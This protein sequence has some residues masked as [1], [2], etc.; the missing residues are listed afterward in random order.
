MIISG[1]PVPPTELPDYYEPL[2]RKLF[3]VME[4]IGASIEIRDVRKETSTLLEIILTLL[5][6]SQGNK[7]STYICGS[8][9]EGTTT[10]GMQ[11]DRDYL[12]VYDDYPVVADK[13]SAQQ[14][15]QCI[16][17]IQD[18]HT[19]AGYAKLQLMH[20]GIPLS[21]DPLR[22]SVR[23]P[24]SF[25]REGRVVLDISSEFE[26]MG[27]NTIRH[28][29]ALTFSIPGFGI[30]GDNVPAV[31]C[32]SWPGCATEW[33]TR[34]RPYNWPGPVLF[35]KCKSLG[36]FFVHV[37]HP[38]SYEKHLQW[39]VSFS[40]QE[41]L[42]VTN[43]NSTQLKCYI[44]MKFMKKE[45]LQPLLKE[46]TITSYHCKTC[47][48]YM[49]EN[50]PAAFWKPERLLPCL[51]SC[52]K[53]I[54]R[55]AE[56]GVCPNFF[57]PDENMFD[58]RITGQLRMRLCSAL[59][60][61][62]SSDFKFLLVLKS[63]YLGTRLENMCIT[64][65]ISIRY[66]GRADAMIS[67]EL[68][69]TFLSEFITFRK[70]DPR[71]GKRFTSSRLLA[72][73][74]QLL[75]TESITGHTRE[76][77]QRAVSLLLPYINLR[78]MSMSIVSAKRSQKPTSV[79]YAALMSDEWHEF[80]PQS[81]PFSVSLKQANYMCVLGYHSVSLNI[82][83]PLADQ[84]NHCLMTMCACTS[85]SFIHD[86]A[87]PVSFFEVPS[88]EEMFKHHVIPCVQFLQDE[89]DLAP[90]ALCYEMISLPGGTTTFDRI[91]RGLETDSATVDGKILLYFLLYLNHRALSMDP[92]ARADSENIQWV[93][94]TDPN[95]HHKTT[96]LN[97]LGWIHK[98]MGRVDK[99]MECFNHSLVIQPEDNAA[100]RHIKDIASVLCF[101]L[102]SERHRK[103]AYLDIS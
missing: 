69:T 86:L 77:T 14:Y 27:A 62:I 97:L 3:K 63:D 44:L 58:G 75:Q 81:E 9:S 54:L 100:I 53:L 8:Q 56:N 35:N 42:L 95:L 72:L 26:N 18:S 64:P 60:T 90:T 4:D 50:T 6:Q 88:I 70:T 59:Q 11:S 103:D 30:T 91:R 51:C 32:H 45:I 25:D 79:I 98:D 16:L 92:Q 94:Q 5:T 47:M 76:E 55:W 10:P 57:I 13:Y 46:D 99:A 37:G 1:N 84:I 12:N 96:A 24:A 41:R 38:Y 89:K 40:L 102:H 19:P 15:N 61:I 20:H 2:S 29:P 52:M 74:Q 101:M 48:F 28:G 68:F 21:V 78:L 43:F 36:C 83:E 49:M 17:M 33:L 31:R 66:H 65:N 67:T 71:T 87:I 80:S 82:L 93:L 7:K 85:R 22:S 34:Q 23:G 39:R 73:K